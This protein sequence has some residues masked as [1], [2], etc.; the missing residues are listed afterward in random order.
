M[1]DQVRGL[2]P[3]V[4]RTLSSGLGELQE[5]VAEVRDGLA[6]EGEQLSQLT[7]AIS[8]ALVNLNVL[9][10]G[11]SLPNCSRPRVS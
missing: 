5:H 2:H 3:S 6:V 10:F 7:M 1:V 9:P 8:D 4:G 11:A